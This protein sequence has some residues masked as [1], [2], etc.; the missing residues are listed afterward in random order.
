MLFGSEPEPE[1]D[2]ETCGICFDP[3][4]DKDLERQKRRCGEF[5]KELWYKG[6][7]K[8]WKSLNKKNKKN[9]SRV[10]CRRL[11]TSIEEQINSL[12]GDMVVTLPCGHKFHTCCL[13]QMNQS[14]N[15]TSKSPTI[16][17]R[18]ITPAKDT[19]ST[20]PI[21]QVLRCPLCYAEV[22]QIVYMTLKGDRATDRKMK[23]QQPFADHPLLRAK[24][25]PNLSNIE[26]FFGETPEEDIIS[27]LEKFN[28][29]SIAHLII[30]THGRRNALLQRNKTF[31]EK[32]GM[33]T[34]E[35]ELL[36][37][38]LINTE[39]EKLAGT[40]NK[41]LKDRASVLLASCDSGKMDFSHDVFPKESALDHALK[42]GRPHGIF[43][44]LNLPTEEDYSDEASC[45]A[46]LLAEHI[47]GH[48][49][50]SHPNLY[51]TAESEMHFRT[52]SPDS[53]EG[54]ELGN[55]GDNGPGFIYYSKNQL[56]YAFL[57]DG[58]ERA[59]VTDDYEAEGEDNITIN[60]GDVLVVTDKS[61]TDWWEGYVEGKPE[62]VGLF[63]ARF[64]EHWVQ[65]KQLYIRIGEEPKKL[66]R[67][68]FNKGWTHPDL[69]GVPMSY[70]SA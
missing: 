20:N 29:N 52:L 34:S 4:Y 43:Y 12:M 28:D 50:F 27:E 17:G 25:A 59:K 44:F 22:P 64:V 56:V 45:F 63:P 5:K 33:T 36:S 51:Y 57:H 26:V 24:F 30:N 49:I 46:N 55:D 42:Q 70:S 61:D 3:L 19:T 13:E 69:F 9:N 8:Q 65:Q 11:D 1:L 10:D 15:E 32:E 67:A 23:N 60:V 35:D 58:L 41:K 18:P 7:L 31:L 53:Y 66:V 47:P 37:N 54:T 62:K 38:S 16:P 6:W 68:K 39:F 2:M 21:L 48:I 40:L 14:Q